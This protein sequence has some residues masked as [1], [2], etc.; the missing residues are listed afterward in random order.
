LKANSDTIIANGVTIIWPNGAGQSLVQALNGG[1]IQFNPGS[2][3]SVTSGGFPSALLAD[4]C[5]IADDMSLS[6][7]NSRGI[8]AVRAQSGGNIQFTAGSSITFSR[9]GGNIGL[10]AS[11]AGSSITATGVNISAGNGGSDVG[12]N[13][14]AGGHVTL[15]AAVFPFRV[16]AVGRGD[17][18]RL[19]PAAW[20]PQP[21]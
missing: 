2:S 9:G 20:A 16:W 8:T 18:K 6:M 4:G 10:T 15:T 3:L 13:A 12:A 7:G 11:G 19:V 17:F 14:A 1:R 21:M 5:I